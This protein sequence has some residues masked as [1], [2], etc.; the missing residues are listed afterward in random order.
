MT[1]LFLATFTITR[2]N[3]Q[4]FLVLQLLKNVP[5]SG[6]SIIRIF[7]HCSFVSVTRHLFNNAILT[8]DVSAV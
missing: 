1:F 8:T 3:V 2:Y 5:Q 4:G 7:K 6:I